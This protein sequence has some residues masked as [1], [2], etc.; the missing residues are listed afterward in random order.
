MVCKKG[1]ICIV[2][3]Y[4]VYALQSFT[5]STNTLLGQQ[6]RV[7]LIERRGARLHSISDKKGNPDG[8][9]SYGTRGMRYNS[10][11]HVSR[12]TGLRILSLR[13]D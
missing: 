8:Y 11:P 12:R 1:G 9:H 7:R 10:L 6:N 3:Q 13:L 2:T 4:A 5:N